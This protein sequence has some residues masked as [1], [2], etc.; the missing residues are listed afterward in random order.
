MSKHLFGIEHAVDKHQSVVSENGGSSPQ[1]IQLEPLA[2]KRL[3]HVHIGNTID[4]LRIL[5]YC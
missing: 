3:L 2:D 5:H 1:D 4:K